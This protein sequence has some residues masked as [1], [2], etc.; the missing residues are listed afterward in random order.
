MLTPATAP[1]THPATEPGSLDLASGLP[2]ELAWGNVSASRDLVDDPWQDADSMHARSY[3]PMVGRFFSVDQGNG[4]PGLPRTWNR[5]SYVGGNPLLR[6]DPDGLA[7]RLAVFV[8]FR[9]EEFT[10]TTKA[11]V[12]YTVA[13][14]RR[15]LSMANR[16]GRF[17]TIDVHDFTDFRNPPTIE[18]LITSIA[19][20]GDFTVYL[21]HAFP[22]GLGPFPDGRY[23]TLDG[24]T[25]R[26]SLVVLAGCG[27]DRFVGSITPPAA[28]N[29]AVLAFGSTVESSE[30]ANFIA[31]LANELR[32]GI[33]LT[34]ALNKAVVPWPAEWR[35]AISLRL[36]GN[37]NAELFQYI[38][39][40]V[41]G[42]GARR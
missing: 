15:D 5:Y 38:N 2:S 29:S 24:A 3:S 14:L 17:S 42:G 16:V 33:G 28:S 36:L 1:T 21:G 35:T 25:N 23:T 41:P 27:T 10:G 34:S 31:M 40:T 4:K 32:P 20:P 26:N 8:T 39:R 11:G 37:P 7:E 9:P 22:Q 12:P 6:V 18:G 19:A 13:S 30:I